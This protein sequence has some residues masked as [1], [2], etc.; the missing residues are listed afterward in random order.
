MSI[1]TGVCRGGEI[2]PSRAICGGSLKL[3]GFWSTFL[4]NAYMPIYVGC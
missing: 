1:Y 4:G 2:D 3:A